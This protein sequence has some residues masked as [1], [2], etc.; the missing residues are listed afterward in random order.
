MTIGN[1]DYFTERARKERTV[2]RAA[3]AAR[4]RKVRDALERQHDAMLCPREIR[5][6]L[7]IVP[8]AATKSTS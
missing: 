5:S 4:A 8:P 6:I 7:S 3:E 2:I 1:A